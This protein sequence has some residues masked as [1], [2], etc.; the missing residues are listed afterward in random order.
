[1]RLAACLA[2]VI[3]VP[4]VIDGFAG[5]PAEEPLRMWVPVQLPVEERRLVN[6]MA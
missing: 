2:L 1:M 6:R 3:L 5:Q 4:K